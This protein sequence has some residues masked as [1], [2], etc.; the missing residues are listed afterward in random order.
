MFNFANIFC[1]VLFVGILKIQRIAQK[2]GWKPLKSSKIHQRN[3][4]KK[5]I[6][7]TA[8]KR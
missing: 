1:F 5:Y 4:C 6:F 8:K 2:K 3:K 7:D